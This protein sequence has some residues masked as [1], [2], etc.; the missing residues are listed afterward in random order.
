VPGQR[1]EDWEKTLQTALKL[2]PDHLSTYNLKIESGT[3]F[4]K[5]L[6][7]GL[8]KPVSEELDLKMYQFTID[9]LIKNGYEHYEVSNFALPGYRSN[10]NQIYWKNER[11]LALGPGAHFYDG[12]VRGNNLESISDYIAKI[13]TDELP[14]DNVKYLSRE[15][16]IV[17]SVILGLR[18]REGIFLEEFNLRF[19]ESITD[20]YNREINKLKEKDLIEITSDRIFLT[21]KGL[22]LANDVL[23]EFIL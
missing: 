1:L 11:Y 22:V 20:I 17:E 19:G 2:E 14:I 4:A 5:D 16:K 23:E 3:K 13:K 10:H 12:E 8:L 21:K 9:Y 18:L 7:K 6:E 15:D